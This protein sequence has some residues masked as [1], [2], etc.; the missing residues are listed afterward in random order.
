M[1]D[2]NRNAGCGPG[3][4]LVTVTAAASAAFNPATTRPEA[5]AASTGLIASRPW[6][7]GDV[8]VPQ[9]APNTPVVGLGYS[10]TNTFAT[11]LGTA[12]NTPARR[13]GSAPS[14]A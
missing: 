9:R 5:H 13:P 1:P 11:V 6:N 7:A 2:T 4:A 12:A 8:A 3:R 10:V 14:E